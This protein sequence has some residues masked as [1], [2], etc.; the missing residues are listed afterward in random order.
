MSRGASRRRQFLVEPG[1]RKVAQNDNSKGVNMMSHNP[2][3]Q[4][5]KVLLGRCCYLPG[6]PT[7]G[8]IGHRRMWVNGG[9]GEV[10]DKVLEQRYTRSNTV[11]AVPGFLPSIRIRY[12]QQ[13]RMGSGKDVRYVGIDDRPSGNTGE[14]DGRAG[15]RGIQ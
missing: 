10:L 1:N 15:A 4:P 5:S 14:S 13:T 8:S 11:G 2:L 12:A 3:V 6:Q 7:R 9:R